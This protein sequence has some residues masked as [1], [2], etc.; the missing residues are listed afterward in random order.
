MLA[1]APRLTPFGW[2]PGTQL[3]LGAT[4]VRRRRVPRSLRPGVVAG[5]PRDATGASRGRCRVDLGTRSTTK[6][7]ARLVVLPRVWITGLLETLRSAP[8][9]QAGAVG[10]RTLGPPA[11]PDG[12]ASPS[13]QASPGRSRVVERAPP[14]VAALS[15]ALPGQQRAP[16][17]GAASPRH[18]LRRCRGAAPKIPPG[19]HARS[20]LRA[21]ERAP[22]VGIEPTSLVLIQSQAGPASR[23]TG[24]R[25][26]RW[27][28]GIPARVVDRAGRT[29]TACDSPGAREWGGRHRHPGTMAW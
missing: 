14:V 18:L 15:S 25:R 17:V 5:R 21:V 24:D 1:T 10:R 3:P 8:R 22:R 11:P 26:A 7:K 2:M 13:R 4:G 27:A 29:T 28:H 20:A 6:M 19:A 23:P 9:T 16:R 12:S